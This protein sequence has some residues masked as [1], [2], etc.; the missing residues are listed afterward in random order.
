MNE[1]PLQPAADSPSASIH[2]SAFTCQNCGARNEGKFCTC[3]GQQQIHEEDLT[4]RHASHHLVHELF[5]VDG[6]IFNT[7]KLLFTRP[8]QLTLDFFEGR[9]ARHVHPIR[10]FLLVG[11]AFFLFARAIPLVDA[12]IAFGDRTNSKVVKLEKLFAE[13]GTTLD[14]VI[15][16]AHTRSAE[17]FKIIY[18]VAILC[19]GFGLWL[20]FRRKRPYLAENMV[21]VLHLACFNMAVWVALGS[22]KWLHLS[23]TVAKVGFVVFACGYFLLASRRV[24]GGSWL[25]LTFKWMFLLGISTVVIAVGYALV[26]FRFFLSFQG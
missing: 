22:L 2:V 19:Q 8:G 18:T 13:K 1:A 26:L 20:I 11:F 5:H 25:A 3:C 6:K 23:M 24:Y 15:A 14:R 4:L 9:R 21:M 16:D 10:L 17:W 7:L 12:G